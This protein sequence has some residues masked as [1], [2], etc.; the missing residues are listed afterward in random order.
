LSTKLKQQQGRPLGIGRLHHLHLCLQMLY[1]CG[2]GGQKLAL[3]GA[4]SA[5]LYAITEDEPAIEHIVPMLQAWM[6]H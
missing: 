6:S 4:N 3:V 5:C 2:G 1:E